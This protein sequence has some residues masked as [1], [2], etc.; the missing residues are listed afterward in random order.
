MNATATVP[1]A[2]NSGPR[3][4]RLMKFEITP[5]GGAGAGSSDRSG[6]IFGDKDIMEVRTVNLR[7]TIG[8]TGMK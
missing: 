1:R 6:S 3:E 4:Q 5:A 2:T 8:E 7:T